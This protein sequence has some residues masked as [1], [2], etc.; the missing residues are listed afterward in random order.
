MIAVSSGAIILSVSKD[1]LL[2]GSALVSWFCG[3]SLNC[4]D[5]G[6]GWVTL[7]FHLVQLLETRKLGVKNLAGKA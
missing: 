3:D 2:R 4:T 6:F 1:P 7:V 5:K